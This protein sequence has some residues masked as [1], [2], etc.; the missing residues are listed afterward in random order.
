MSWKS[1]I[2]VGL[3]S[4]A[5]VPPSHGQ[6]LFEELLPR[7]AETESQPTEDAESDPK[8]DEKA[9]REAEEKKLLDEL[10]KE[11]EDLIAGKDKFSRTV[12]DLEEKFKAEFHL[13]EQKFAE[14]KPTGR[15]RILDRQRLIAQYM[16]DLAVRV[17]EQRRFGMGDNVRQVNDAISKFRRKHPELG[18][19]ERFREMQREMPQRAMRNRRGFS[20]SHEQPTLTAMMKRLSSGEVLTLDE[21]V[22]SNW[23][24]PGE[25][26]G[27]ITDR[28]AALR[29]ML[30]LRWEGERLKIDR[31]H[32]D[33]PFAGQS[34]SDVREEVN[35]MLEERGVELDARQ[36]QRQAMMLQ[37]RTA[38]SQHANVLRLF[39]EL[40]GSTRTSYGRTANGDTVRTHFQDSAL[41]ARMVASST[42][43][44]LVLQELNGPNRM[45]RIAESEKGL[46]IV[47]LGDSLIHRFQQGPDGKVSVVEVLDD[48]VLNHQAPTAARLYGREARFTEERI[49]ALLDHLGIVEPLTRFHPEVIQQLMESLA[50]DHDGLQTEVRR[51]VKSLDANRFAEREKAYSQLKAGIEEYYE[52]LYRSRHDEELSREVRARI[53]KLLAFGSEDRAV[54]AGSLVSAMGLTQDADYLD[55]VRDLIGDSEREL[56]DGRLKQLLVSPGLIPS[57]PAQALR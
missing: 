50:S 15:R 26:K 42:S 19:H 41:H 36:Q 35:A 12:S 39:D 38:N 22:E 53:T 17:N 32:W 33:I 57:T 46:S 34:P 7:D 40:R 52:C 3:F 45:F 8:L 24:H 48:E 9:A 10:E 13:N 16:I 28:R 43:F 30:K 4:I 29:S 55:Q 2:V 20:G 25:Q 49:F 31:S 51:L 14:A 1:V 21:E 47:L 11:L 5:F 27:P 37:Q 56:V 18:R 54:H 44:E 6:G 23:A